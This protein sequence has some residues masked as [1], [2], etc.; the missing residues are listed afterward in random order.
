M[1]FG[2]NES[3]FLRARL[4]D[5]INE[6][7][8]AI[9]D[10]FG[11]VNLEPDSVLGELTAII[12]VPIAELY[13]IAEQVYFSQYPSTAEGVSLDNTVDLVGIKRLEATPTRVVL[14]LTG[15]QATAIAANSVVRI[16]DSGESFTN[17]L[18]GVITRSNAL[19]VVFNVTVATI[20][21]VYTVSI[22]GAAISITSGSVSTSVE[23]IAAALVA[24]IN[25][26]S[27][28]IA[29]TATDN[30]DGSFSILS[31]DGVT[32]FDAQFGAGLDII[33]L[34]SGLEFVSVNKAPVLAPSNSVTTI[35][36]PIAGWHSVTNF[37]SGVLGRN[38]ETDNEL[39]IRRLQSLKVTGAGSVEAIQA[40][41]RQ[42]VPA[43]LN[44]LVFENRMPYVVN[45][46]PPHS[47]EA[48]VVGGDDNLIANEIWQV[49]PAG[50]QTHGTEVVMISDSNGNP[51]EIKFSRPTPVYIWVQ[52]ALTVTNGVFPLDGV[53]AV[54][55]AIKSTGDLFNVGEDIIYQQFFG[56][57]YTVAGI[58]EVTLQFGTSSDPNIPPGGY[59]T[60]NIT[61]NDVEVGLFDIA[62]IN[63]TVV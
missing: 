40:R 7:Q 28:T 43:V 30:L 56:A 52:A 33:T 6:I 27:L 54:A 16:N 15:L 55:A 25:N 19:Y 9:I 53:N 31:D 22:N 58:L 62:R 3:G 37:S 51:Q 20:N 4:N 29:L 42:F 24:A 21:T 2:L 17:P 60:G 57:I 44:A 50:I 48:L 38:R 1:N 32:G 14:A 5:V 63:V 23:A 35:V 47:F 36:T 12:A 59:T 61:I 34:A 46:R 13:E 39:R 41:L 49:K 45:G 11:A 8:A 10:A 18:A 26:A